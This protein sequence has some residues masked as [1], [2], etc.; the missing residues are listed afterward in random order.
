MKLRKSGTIPIINERYNSL[1]S[2]EQRKKED[3]K[4]HCMI[5]I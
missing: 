4:L 2:K 1:E 5:F 3:K